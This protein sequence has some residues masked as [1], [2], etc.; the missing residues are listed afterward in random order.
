MSFIQF[1][2]TKIAKQSRGI[3]DTYIYRTKDTCA[4]VSAAGYFD[5]CRFA[6]GDPDSWN[7]AIIEVLASDCY[8]KGTIVN[9]DFVALVSS[10][11]V[12]PALCQL[13]TLGPAGPENNSTAVY[14]LN[15]Y[16]VTNTAGG[17]NDNSGFDVS[18]VFSLDGGLTVVFSLTVN[19]LSQLSNDGLIGIAALDPVGF[20]VFQGVTLQFGSG[21]DGEI[22]FL[23]SP[24]AQLSGLTFPTFPYT[25]QMEVAE[26]GSA[27]F[28]D[29]DAT[30][31]LRTNLVVP[32]EGAFTG[33]SVAL[34]SLA[35][36]PLGAGENIDIT[37]NGG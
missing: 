5:E 2:V 13:L 18:T 25:M 21:V 31:P 10:G 14:N 28:S 11:G 8:S 29:E 24:S 23:G 15:S 22:R 1:Q 6:I 35:A 32:T 37:M 19:S 20:A 12:A 36:A 27:A 34:G 3:F 17:P 26:D 4:E 16:V 30:G 33:L 9:G 7:F